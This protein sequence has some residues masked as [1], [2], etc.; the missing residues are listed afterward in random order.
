MALEGTEKGDAFFCS[1]SRWLQAHRKIG[2][3]KAKLCWALRDRRKDP[4]W[5]SDC[6]LN[7]AEGA[8][9]TLKRQF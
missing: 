1:D 4:I 9:K 7:D 5:Q 6:Q 3:F 8:K 2:R